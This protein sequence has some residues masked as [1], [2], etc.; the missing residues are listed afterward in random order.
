MDDTADKRRHQRLYLLNFRGVG[1]STWS[2]EFKGGS[3]RSIY[4]VY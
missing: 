1:G 3:R 2:A 4:I